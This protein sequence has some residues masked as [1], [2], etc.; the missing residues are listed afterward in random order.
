MFPRTAYIGLFFSFLLWTAVLRIPVIYAYYMV[1]QSDFIAR[2]CENKDKPEMN[3]D[4]KCYLSKMMQAEQEA[5][6]E[7]AMPMLKWSEIR[8]FWAAE[9]RENSRFAPEKDQ[10]A[11]AWNQRY[12]YQPLTYCFR[13]PPVLPAIG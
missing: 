13:P 8:L 2:L 11:D 7:P 9:Q 4:G 5:D 1:A 12:A 10:P 6:Q 3:C